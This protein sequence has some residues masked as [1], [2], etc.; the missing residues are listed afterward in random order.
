MSVIGGERE[1]RVPWKRWATLLRRGARERVPSAEWC[2]EVGVEGREREEG[3]KGEG[4]GEG[5]RK[6]SQSTF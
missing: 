5:G 1:H 4:E 2:W 3:G 6:Q